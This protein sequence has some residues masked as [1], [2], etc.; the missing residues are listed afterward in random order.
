MSVFSAIYKSMSGLLGFTQGL[1]NISQNIANMNT[2][3]Y[4]GKDVFSRELAF[5]GNGDGVEVSGSGLRMKQGDIV[6]T[7]NDT[8]VAID[9]N[10]FFVLL[11]EGEEFYTRNG[12]FRIDD[13][14][15]LIDSSSRLRVASL[16][17]DND[18]QDFHVDINQTIDPIAT[19]SIRLR[20]NLNASASQGDTFPVDSS[21][22][23]FEV[24][25]FDVAGELQTLRFVFTKD[26]GN[27]WSVQ[28][29]DSQNIDIGTPFQLA[30]DGS[31]APIDGQNSYSFSYASPGGEAFDITVVFGDPGSFAGLT[32]F[33]SGS[34]N[35]EALEVDGRSLGRLISTSFDESG[36]LT[37]SFSNG[38]SV[39]GPKLALA[40]FNNPADLV[41]V[42]G[43]VFK[44]SAG[45][46]PEIGSAGDGVFGDIAPESIELSNVELSREFA[47]LIIV[48]RGYQAS[49][50]VL[51]AT[52][53]L[54]E[55]LY[56][57][58]R[59]N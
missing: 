23:P 59:G 17:G 40:N 48:Q 22:A 43:S 26:V 18:I 54:I 44:A 55:E 11:S 7:S 10:G 5:G 27:V 50:Q 51:N 32:G 45:I 35:L 6:E 14:G 56:N 38:E 16:D 52:N 19:S 3:G 34:S 47:D 25:V 9:G 41:V 4:K 1:D 33:S 21:A 42:N 46:S 31:G 39:T 28:A 37:L 53:E 49:S 58:T 12:Q 57:S 2:P 24:E 15:F 13:Q 29:R 36:L 30:F 8:D 20:G